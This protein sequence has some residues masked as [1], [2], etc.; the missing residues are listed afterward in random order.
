MPSL[1]MANL[2]CFVLF[3]CL[4]PMGF[5]TKT[6]CGIAN[7]LALMRKCGK[8]RMDM[9]YVQGI[10]Q[11]EEMLNLTYL[12]ST[13][14]SG[15]NILI[16][17]PLLISGGLFLCMEF[18]KILDVNPNTPGLSIGAVKDNIM[19]GS[20]I[21]IQDAGRV[22][23]HDIEIYVGIYLVVGIFIGASNMIGAFSYW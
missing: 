21:D 16:M 10:A 12:M 2:L 1:K 5:Y 3:F 15:T 13:I 23:K 6:L 19:R 4:Y 22:L 20:G 17:M 18:K 7:M 14:P 8:P 9:Q 11:H